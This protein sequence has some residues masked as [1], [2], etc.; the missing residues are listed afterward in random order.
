MEITKSLQGCQMAFHCPHLQKSLS[1]H[2]GFSF[3]F[4]WNIRSHKVSFKVRCRVL[5]MDKDSMT[6]LQEKSS[7]CHRWERQTKPCSTLCRGACVCL[8]SQEGLGSRDTLGDI[9]SFCAYLMLTVQGGLAGQQDQA[10]QV[11]PWHLLVQCPP[12]VPRREVTS[13][14]GLNY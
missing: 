13:I 9:S 12:W 11:G 7:P 8:M 2:I 4:I 14:S 1:D 6:C 10:C 5:I 3:G